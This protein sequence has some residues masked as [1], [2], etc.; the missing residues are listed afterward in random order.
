M[1]PEMFTKEYIYKRL[2]EFNPVGSKVSQIKKNLLKYIKESKISIEEFNHYILGS[3]YFYQSYHKNSLI[4]LIALSELKNSE[5]INFEI[6]DLNDE[7]KR[8]FMNKLKSGWAPKDV[9]KIL[10]SVQKLNISFNNSDLFYFM[11]SN[12]VYALSHFK[13]IFLRD[14]IIKKFFINSFIKHIDY[15]TSPNFEEESYVDDS[16]INNF[17]RELLSLEQYKELYC[18]IKDF[19]IFINTND[20]DHSLL[21]IKRTFPEYINCL[22]ITNNFTSFEEP[23]IQ[24]YKKIEFNPITFDKDKAFS[25]YQIS[26]NKLYNNELILNDEFQFSSNQ[27]FFDII[28]IPNSSF[29]KAVEIFNHIILNIDINPFIPYKNNKKTLFDFVI[30]IF[31]V[32]PVKGY[33]ENRKKEV[34]EKYIMWIDKNKKYLNSNLDIQTDKI[35]QPFFKTYI[36]NII[37]NLDIQKQPLNIKKNRL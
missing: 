35:K 19:K 18:L 9:E 11:T 25:A 6:P 34:Y 27:S 2:K 37:L 16:K 13:N 22:L 26:K 1:S 30:D 21:Y 31:N 33:Q 36:E 28:N 3:P 15:N 24:I 29:G 14:N 23:Y 20:K 5:H 12:D 4:T 8:I 32:E 7:T 17:S 10:K